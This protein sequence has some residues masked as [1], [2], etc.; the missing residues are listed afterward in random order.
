MRVSASP[1]SSHL[2]SVF[3]VGAVFAFGGCKAHREQD[4]VTQVG[5][6][7]SA[8]ERVLASASAAAAAPASVES[9]ASNVLGPAE[10]PEADRGASSPFCRQV[11]RQARDTNAGLPQDLDRDT[12]ATR[13]MAY[14]CDVI[15]EYAMLD[16]SADQ[17]AAD[18]VSAM[19]DEVVRKLCSDKGAHGVLD[20]GGS[21]TSVYRD[22]RS[23]LIDQFTVGLDDCSELAS[24]AR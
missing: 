5:M 9:G 4:V 21:F 16:M 2:L 14:G 12:R 1:G 13:V 8:S 11:E 6:L 17:V 22:D 18:G 24:A 19:R 20:H 15:L 23:A 10:F 7:R 3:V